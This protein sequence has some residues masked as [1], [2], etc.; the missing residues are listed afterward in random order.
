M[1]DEYYTSRGKFITEK[2]V[3]INNGGSIGGDSLFRACVVGMAFS[4]HLHIVPACR[5]RL[6]LPWLVKL[7]VAN[8]VQL[9]LL[10]ADSEEATVTVGQRGADRP[11]LVPG[12]FS[13]HA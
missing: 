13:H 6:H 4:A 5:G 12:G 3:Q 2:W 10:V 1:E 9:A 7:L 8:H 11:L